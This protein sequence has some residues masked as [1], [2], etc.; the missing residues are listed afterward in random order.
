ML[1][2]R[3]TSTSAVP[4]P[5]TSATATTS[6]TGFLDYPA[7]GANGTD[8]RRRGSSG[9][10]CTKQTAEYLLKRETINSS[11]LAMHLHATALT[12]TFAGL[13]ALK[14]AVMKVFVA[15]TSALLEPST[16]RSAAT[17]SAGFWERAAL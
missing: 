16:A 6:F 4:E 9:Q 14:P 11:Y 3:V 13:H 8:C 5:R 15:C 7:F 17:D 2:L 1:K 12:R 10:Y